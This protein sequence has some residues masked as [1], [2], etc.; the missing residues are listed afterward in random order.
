MYLCLYVCIY[1]A[2]EKRGGHTPYT[3]EDFVANS[4]LAF[5]W[6]RESTH[7]IVLCL[8][9][10]HSIQTRATAQCP[11][12]VLQSTLEVVLQSTLRKKYA[13]TLRRT[14]LFLSSRLLLTMANGGR[15]RRKCLHNCMRN[16]RKARMQVTHGIGEKADVLGPGG[17]RVRTPASTATSLISSAASKQ[18]STPVAN[19]PFGSYGYA[20]EI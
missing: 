13:N 15:Y 19:G 18:I 20:L 10:Q 5:F 12:V 8:H 3:Q 11:A 6:R 9:I 16:T 4:Q 2:F 1:H 14:R 7:H 17:L